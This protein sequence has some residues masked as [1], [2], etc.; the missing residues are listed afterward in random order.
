VFVFR[1]RAYR[2]VERGR[3]GGAAMIGAWIDSIPMAIKAVICLPSLVIA[4]MMFMIGA[5][6]LAPGPKEGSEDE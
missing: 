1:R 2:V 6:L 3:R 5:G 4:W